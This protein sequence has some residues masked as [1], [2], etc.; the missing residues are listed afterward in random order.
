[1]LH[2]CHRV[3]VRYQSLGTFRF[4]LRLGSKLHVVINTRELAKVVVRDQD[5]AFSNSDQTIAVLAATYGG[6]DIVFSNNSNWRK[7]RKIFVHE[8]MG[9]KNLEASGYFRKDEVRKTIKNV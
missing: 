9:N 6:Q 1:M 2:H 5:E 8:I 4:K 3:P 7:L